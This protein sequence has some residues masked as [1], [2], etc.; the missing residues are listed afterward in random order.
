MVHI[1][2]IHI[3][4]VRNSAIL[5]HNCRIIETTDRISAFDFIFPFLVQNKGKILQ[6]LSFWMFENTKHIIENH[7]I[8]VLDETHILVKNAEVFP[9]E[10]IMRGYL[11]GSLWR[12]YSKKGPEGVLKEYGIQLP[13]NMTQN[14]KLPH[15][16]LTPS[17]KAAF[18]HDLPL[19]L[20]KS[21][22]LVGK[23]NWN[24]I[25]TKAHELFSFGRL[26]ADKKNLIL[27]DTKYEMG[28]YENQ[29]ILVDEVHTPDSSRYW[30]KSAENNVSPKQISKEFL[31]EEIIRILGQP[32]Q[33]TTNPIYHPVFQ[34]AETCDNLSRKVS[35]RYEELFTLFTGF[36][37]A[38]QIYKENPFHPWPIE[39]EIFSRTVSAQILPKKI[40]VVG[41]GGRDFVLATEFSKL[42]E[43]ET[44]YCASGN[45]KWENQK[46]K[47]CPETEVEQIAKFAKEHNVGLVL[48]GPEAPI[49]QGLEKFCSEQKIPVLAPTLAC[50]ALETSK[51]LCKQL[52]ELAGVKTAAYKII[53]W[54]ELKE[55]LNKKQIQIP[56]VLKFDGLAA[57]KGV[58]ILK[59]EKDIPVTL[60]SIESQL[61]SWEN[62]S[63]NILSES[64]SKKNKEP[65]FLWEE[66]IVGEEFSA[67][68]LC[69]GEDYRLLPIAK[70]YKR[71][72]NN[73]E[74][75]NTGGMGS[76]AP[77]TLNDPLL[78]QVKTSFAL[79]LKELTKRGTPYH[80]FL[81]AGFMVDKK[82]CAYLLEY[83]CRLG[84]PETQ[85]VLP[86]LGRD[87]FAELYMTAKKEPFLNYE[88][89]GT[90]FNHDAL[91]RVFV[92][93]AA[94]EYPE[95]NSP[96]R[97]VISPI[98]PECNDAQIEFI[99]SAL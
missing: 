69:N 72:N 15:P 40:L 74:G 6:A 51:I 61:S 81:F 97:K 47:L 71:R 39:K 17:T 44:V 46:I 58:F 65:C 84:D 55:S 64:Y 63:E 13:P 96:R 32:E 88:K 67:I 76:I 50:V 43:V 62:I 16:I 80:G 54:C 36:K 91:T 22:E 68:A 48:A 59:T 28:F 86:G 1:E 99:P 75:P 19:S 85:V 95:R 10:I 42:A 33:L 89:S 57:G 93:G 79:T 24:F 8:G 23:H 26:E 94:P 45:R 66:L 30:L 11:V 9:I 77:I 90:I 25:S 78:S 73:Q 83:N 12:L 41:N 34:D 20:K 37:K 82:D 29:I 70:D 2:S 53:P 5:N 92:V 4:K 60:K 56:C 18:G 49:A 31:R 27:V 21:E 3:G 14:Q 87:F 35:K 98:M 38:D 7:L 52:I